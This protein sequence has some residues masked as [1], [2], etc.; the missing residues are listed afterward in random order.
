[1][2]RILVTGARGQLGHDVVA[3]L[4]RRGHQAV[5]VDIEE[6]DI[7]DANAVR[8]VITAAHVTGVIHC[9]AYT[10]VDA[11]EENQELC[12]KVNVEGTRNIAFVCKDLDLKMIYLSTDYVFNG[13]GENFWKPDD[14]REPLN[15]YG[16]SKYQG[17]LVVESLLEK[18]FIV[19]I[20]WVFGKNG[21]NFVKTML[22]LGKERDSVNV[23]CDQV[24]SPT[25]TVDLAP[26]LCDMIVSEKYGVY[27]ATN[28]GTCSWAEFAKEIFRVAGMDVKVNPISTS[29]YPTKATRPLNSRLEKRCLNEAGFN[30]LRSWEEALRDVLFN[31]S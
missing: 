9:A 12:M 10:A 5:P 29:Q 6:M 1:M 18:Y 16:E 19:R 31:A 15:V 17:E 2:M 25:Y 13:E 21:N 14:K 8:K 22:R 24:G 3:E 4:K 7:T 11:A 27:H 23:V 20:A 26:L 30:R 28:E